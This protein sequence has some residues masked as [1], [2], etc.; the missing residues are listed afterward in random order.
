LFVYFQAIS[1]TT[2]PEYDLQKQRNILCGNC[3]FKLPKM[4][5]KATAFPEAERLITNIVKEN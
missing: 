2:K 5:I 4:K 1:H 3:K